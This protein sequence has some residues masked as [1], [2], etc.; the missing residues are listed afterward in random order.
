M[1]ILQS[2]RDI[3]KSF[4]DS[5]LSKEKMRVEVIGKMRIQLSTVNLGLNQIDALLIDLSALF[6]DI[7]S[8][9]CKSFIYTI[10]LIQ[11]KGFLLR[12]DLS[13]LIDLCPGL[14]LRGDITFD[15][16]L[17]RITQWA[18][19]LREQDHLTHLRS[20]GLL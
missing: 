12:D 13:Q 8:E 6:D 1:K 9:E 20:L 17:A 5:L 7:D 3:F 4:E 15:N 19:I 10:C 16:Y 18:N 2:L 11:S 14:F